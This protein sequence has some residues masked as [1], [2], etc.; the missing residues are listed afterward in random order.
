MTTKICPGCNQ[1]RDAEADF[2]WSIRGI[3]RHSRCNTC[4]SKERSERYERNKEAELAYK[5]ERQD[6]KREEARKYVWDYLS[7]KTC[8]DCGEYDPLV[9][10]F[11]HVRGN[12]KMNVS[13]MV[14]QGYSFE[15]IR[16]EM[17]K[18]E[19]VCNNCHLR[20]EKKRRNTKY[21]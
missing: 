18:C 21:W 17:A 6:R 3:K 14:N 15:A 20:R 10:T 13:Q 8:V 11:D 2:S 9:L 19:V 16:E 4:R 5:Y 1:P 7:R 12:K